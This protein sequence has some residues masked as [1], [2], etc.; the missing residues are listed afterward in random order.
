MNSRGAVELDIVLLALNHGLIT[1]EVFS[2]L[3]TISIITPLMF[4]FIL[5]H[6]IKKNT[7]ALEKPNR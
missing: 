7:A 2:S 3:V 1:Q 5:Q 6:E 4:P